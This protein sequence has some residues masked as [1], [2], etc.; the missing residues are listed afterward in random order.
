MKARRL[1]ESGEMDDLKSEMLPQPWLDDYGRANKF[2]WDRDYNAW[3]KR[4]KLEQGYADML[5]YPGGNTVKILVKLGGQPTLMA[6]T[7][8]T[9]PNTGARSPRVLQR[10]EKSLAEY[11]AWDLN[12]YRL[13]LSQVGFSTGS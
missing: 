13:W 1:I 11:S 12:E 9:D 4:I 2:K 3:K 5:L 8:T 10:L 6:T 7:L